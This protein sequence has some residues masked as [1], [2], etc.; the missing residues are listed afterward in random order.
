[1]SHWNKLLKGALVRLL[2]EHP[3]TSPEDLQDW[4]HPEGFRLDPS[5]T[6]LVGDVTVLSLVRS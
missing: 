4:D 5:R 3:S 6:L 2:L 1:M